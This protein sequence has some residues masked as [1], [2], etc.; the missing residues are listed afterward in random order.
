MRPEFD[1][2]DIDVRSDRYF[3][4]RTVGSCGRCGRP[5]V[6]VAL[7]LP[8]GHER[9]E[10]DEDLPQGEHDEVWSRADRHA[11][12]FHVDNLSAAAQRHVRDIA[13]CYDFGQDETQ[14]FQW[15]N[16]CEHCG[17]QLD[18]LELFCEPDGPFLPTSEAGAR[19]IRLVP[20]DEPIEARAAGL[21]DEPEFFNHMSR[22]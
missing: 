9:L 6:V 3:I 11:F 12:L 1:E 14:G 10:V 15:V 17:T 2:T 13:P 7:C 18:D 5:T 20:I 21:A 19:V 16:H 22:A 4:A 8:P